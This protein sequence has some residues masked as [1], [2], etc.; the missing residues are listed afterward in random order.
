MGLVYLQRYTTEKGTLVACCDEEIIG[1]TFRQ[2]KLK[3]SIE[4]KFYGKT[5]IALEEALRMLVPAEM[6]NLAG[7]DIVRAAITQGL[8]HPD[9]VIQIDGIPHVQVLKM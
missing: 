7:H 2:G 8:V 4:P 5:A 1:K 6:M 3:L 9:A